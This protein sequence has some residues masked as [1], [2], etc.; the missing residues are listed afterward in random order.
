MKRSQSRLFLG[1]PLDQVNLLWCEFPKILELQKNHSSFIT[2]EQELFKNVKEK[3]EKRNK[4]KR[5]FVNSL[6]K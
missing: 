5:Y 4:L 2:L 3:L 1:G 6:I